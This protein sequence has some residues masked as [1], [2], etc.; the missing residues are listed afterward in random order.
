MT[1]ATVADAIA[2]GGSAFAELSERHR[3]ELLPPTL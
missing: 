3:R 1:G 2:A